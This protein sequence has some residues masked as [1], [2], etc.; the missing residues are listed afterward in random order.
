MHRVPGSY[1]THVCCLPGDNSMPALQEAQRHLRVHFDSSWAWSE[2]LDMRGMSVSSV[3]EMWPKTRTSFERI[4]YAPVRLLLRL[5]WLSTLCRMRRPKEEPFG[6]VSCP[7][8]AS[9]ALP[10]LPRKCRV[11]L[12]PGSAEYSPRVVLSGL[13]RPMPIQ[14]RTQSRS[15]ALRQES[16]L[17]NEQCATGA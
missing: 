8:D 15:Y 4:A 5:L 10:R 11:R 7:L 13:N 14:T 3:Q 1:K 17:T 16:V 6:C 2:E 12:A 9:L